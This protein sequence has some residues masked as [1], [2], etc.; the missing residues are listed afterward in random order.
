[1]NDGQHKGEYTLMYIPGAPVGSDSVK[2][3]NNKEVELKVD[4]GIS[5][6]FLASLKQIKSFKEFFISSNPIIDPF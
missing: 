2:E 1:M 5:D 6:T 3:D 4:S